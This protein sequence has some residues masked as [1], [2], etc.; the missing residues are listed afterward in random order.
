[1]PSTSR[2]SRAA[3]S[4]DPAHVAGAALITLGL[5]QLPFNSWIARSWMYWPQLARSG[6]GVLR[7]LLAVVRALAPFRLVHAYGVFSPL[8]GPSLQWV[9]RFEASQDGVNFEPYRYRYYPSDVAFR[10]VRVAP[11]FPRFDHSIIYEAMGLGLGNLFGCVVGGGRPQRA[12]RALYFERV[13]RRLLEAAPEVLALF[14]R[15]PFGGARPAAV[16]VRFH[17]HLWDGERFTEHQAGDHLPCAT[18]A[19][20]ESLALPV[21]RD[22]PV[23]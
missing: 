17:I 19:T 11:L 22:L 1:M 4:F 18:L 6:R 2:P 12:S 20:C 16:R 10:G 9:P 14:A 21:P 3:W 8:S 13:Q 7:P 5:V 15:A 23:R